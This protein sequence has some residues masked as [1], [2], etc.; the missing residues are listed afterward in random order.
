MSQLGSGERDQPYE[1]AGLDWV[2]VGHGGLE[3]LALRRRLAQ[4]PMQP[5][6]Q[7]RRGLVGHGCRL[8]S[9]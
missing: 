6:Q 2:V 9:L 5:A 8:S 4:L 1:P 7:A 3:V